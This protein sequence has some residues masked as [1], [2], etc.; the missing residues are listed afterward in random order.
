M[1]IG[2]ILVVAPADAE[3]VLRALAAAGEPRAVRIGEITAGSGQ[4]RYS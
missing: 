4:V 1:G 2:L 3:A